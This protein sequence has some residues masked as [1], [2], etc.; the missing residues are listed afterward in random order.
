MERA[1]LTVKEAAAVIGISLPKAYELAH[2]AGFPSFCVGRKILIDRMG[3]DEWRKSQ[4][5]KRAEG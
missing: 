4:Q 1:T 5:P 2:S 3:L